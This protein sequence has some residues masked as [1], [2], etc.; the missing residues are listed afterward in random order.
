[1]LLHGMRR[2]TRSAMDLSLPLSRFLEMVSSGLSPAV[3][4]RKPPSL[5]IVEFVTTNM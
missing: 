2:W 5:S 4:R 1:M 3:D